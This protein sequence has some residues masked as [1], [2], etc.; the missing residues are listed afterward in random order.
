MPARGEGA[1]S[2][3]LSFHANP[4]GTRLAIPNSDIAAMRRATARP[5]RL[6]GGLY[7]YFR[8]THH[9]GDGSS[10]AVVRAREHLRQHRE[11]ADDRVQ[12]GRHE[13]PGPDSG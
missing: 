3:L 4:R 8:R 10:R 7:G 9:G 13:F 5:A 1:F 12:A 11:L 6:I 2:N